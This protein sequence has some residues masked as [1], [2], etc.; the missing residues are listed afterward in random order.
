MDIKGR[1]LQSLRLRRDGLLLR[2]DAK[3]FGSPSQVSAAL[4]SLADSSLI[5]KLDRVF[6]LSH[7]KWRNWVG[8]LYW[9]WL[10]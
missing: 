8:K 10:L 6:M 4:R 5:E 1:I 2:Q 7:P 3:S 9:K